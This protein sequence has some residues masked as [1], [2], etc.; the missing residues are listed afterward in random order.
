MRRSVALRLLRIARPYLG[1]L[2]LALAATAIASALDGVTIV[3]LVPLL[4]ALFGTA[5]VLAGEATALESVTDRLLG[6]LLAGR[7]AGEAAALVVALLLLA[8]VLKNLF[9]YGAS[10]LS[11]AVQEGLVRDLRVR[12]YRH[13]L[14]VD[15]DLLQRTRQG[16]L[17]AGVIADA[18]QCKLAVTAALVAF[19]QNLALIASSLVILAGISWRLTLLTL[20]AAPVLVVGVRHLLRRLLRHAREWAEERGRITATVSER[21]SAVELIR[22][23]GG[24]GLEAEA[25][26]VQADDYRRRAIRTQRFAT[27]THPV[28]EVFGGLVVILVIWAAANPA[29]S[30]VAMG[31][32]VTI[33]FLAAALKMMSPLKALSQFPTSMALA[34]GGAERVF[35]WLDLPEVER[36]EPGQGLARF[37]RDLEFDRVT[38]AY[39]GEPPALEGV[40]FR[41]AKGKM[42]AVVGPSGSGKTT[43]LELLPRLRDPTAGEIRLDGVPLTRLTRD[44]VRALMGVVAQDAIVLNDTVRANIAYAR[45][46]ATA[47]AV[48]RAAAA[49]N[50]LEFIRR[51]PAGFDTVLG[52]RGARL[53]GGQ[54][55]RIAI[56]RALL[57]D[58]PLLILDEATSALDPESE[59]LVREAIDRLMADRTV[60]VVAHRLAT[61][62]NADEILV[63][64]RGRIVERGAHAQLLAR[65]GLYRRLHDLQ[66]DAALVPA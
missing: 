43:L 54:R 39:P 3:A 26:A 49:A 40:S 18:D 31:P 55:Q 66:F 48:E 33:V 32:E 37:E 59:R 17:I 9:A 57:R 14:A 21:L 7:G 16:Q 47:D 10:Q 15:L 50:A 46:D 22:G 63:L 30:G 5:G 64:D 56:A 61:V 24:A 25:F 52:E 1:L 27:L 62:L 28:S 2:A 41:V 42:V 34:L 13:L 20:A 65:S 29:I 12:L 51:L 4:K 45:P 8:L 23:Y 38:F 11:V 60:L 44:S 35:H 36:D 19:F 6:P 58:P 53:S